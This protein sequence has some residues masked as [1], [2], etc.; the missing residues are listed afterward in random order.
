MQPSGC[1]YQ[2]FAQGLPLAPGF[3]DQELPERPTLPEGYNRSAA[4]PEHSVSVALAHRYASL[5]RIPL[6]TDA[7]S[8]P[9][10]SELCHS[11]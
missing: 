6:R 7:G 11:R 8:E 1:L 3:R 2:G 10:I 5:A 9:I 4:G